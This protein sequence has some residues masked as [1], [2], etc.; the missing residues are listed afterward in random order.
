MRLH[1]EL[2]QIFQVEAV[3]T[4]THLINHGP[5]IPLNFKLPEEVQSGKKV[6]LSYLKVFSCV[7]YVLVDSSARSNLCYFVGNGDSVLGYHLWDDQNWNIVRNNDVI[8]NEAVLYKDRTLKSEAKKPV[9][10]PL[11]IFPESEDGN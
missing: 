9:A 4:A 7:S 8:L 11:K 6:D 5:S 2:S 10:I 3:N 1:V